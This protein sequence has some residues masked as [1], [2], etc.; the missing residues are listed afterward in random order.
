MQKYLKHQEIINKSKTINEHYEL[1]DELFDDVVD[2]LLHSELDTEEVILQ[3]FQRLLSEVD[4]EIER[5]ETFADMK[6]SCF[7]GCA[8]CCYFP[9]I[10]SKMEAK[11]MFRSIEKF[12]EERRKEIYAHWES[13]YKEY[14]EKLNHAMSLDHTDEGTKFE[15]KKLNLPCPMLDPKTQACMAYE[16]R[17][18]PCRTY[19]NYSDPEVCAKNHLPKEPFSYE[20]LYNYYF[21]SLNELLQAL[22]ENG[23]ELNVDYPSDAWSYHFLPGW[24]EK[25]RKETWNEL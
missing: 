3:G 20:F 2:S 11:I 23:E 14:E 12:P 5:M 6:P 16:I 18:I 17:P 9:I 10:I 22:Y 25:W 7:K 13:Y 21:S 8:F 19:L 15:Y 1:D 4:S 24:I